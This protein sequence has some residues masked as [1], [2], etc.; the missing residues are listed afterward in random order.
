MNN[1]ITIPVTVSAANKTIPVSMSAKVVT[2]KVMTVN[3]LGAAYATL[4]PNLIPENIRKGIT[5]YGI[6]G[7]YE[8]E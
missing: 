4:D 6:T 3:H 7:T 1:T 2:P 5:I 8:G